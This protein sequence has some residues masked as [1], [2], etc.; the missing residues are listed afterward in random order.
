MRQL[1]EMIEILSN[2][3]NKQRLSNKITKINKTSRK[4][5]ENLDAECCTNIHFLPVK[6]PI[7]NIFVLF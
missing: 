7:G 5:V 3:L 4:Q 1:S 2:K 6:N